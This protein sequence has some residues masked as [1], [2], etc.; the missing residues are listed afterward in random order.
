MGRGAISSSLKL[1]LLAMP[2]ALGGCAMTS[3]YGTGQAPEMALFREMTG[4]LLSRND[5]KKPIEYQP[6]APLVLPK[7]GEQL[8][9]P[10]QTASAADPDWPIDPD[11]RIL[12]PDDGD[13]NPDNDITQEDYRRLKPL[14]GAFGPN[15]VKPVRN[16]FYDQE[17]DDFYAFVHQGTDQR[18][19]FS[20]SIAES[21]GYTRT[22]RRY[23]TDPPL[24]Y[25]E[26]AATAPTEEVE[27]GV[28]KRGFW[29]KL[30]PGR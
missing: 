21:K 2:V 28:K 11:E 24:A 22:E 9:E 23:L 15:R 20:K 19:S 17:R 10:V 27:T 16:N 14:T 26:P 18:K 6:R 12:T 1:L 7:P 13:G 3:T 4:G 8:P 25:R 29:R 5:E 30:L